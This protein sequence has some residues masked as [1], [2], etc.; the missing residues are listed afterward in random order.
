VTF[1][2]LYGFMVLC[3]ERRRVVH[4]NVTPHPTAPWVA[5]QIQEAF[6]FDEAPRSLIRDRDA[7]SGACFREGLE[8][9][10]VEE[11]LSAPRSPWQTP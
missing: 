3:H 7:A 9:M 10:G 6:P 2:L 4:F 11:V 8:R 1:R 5:R